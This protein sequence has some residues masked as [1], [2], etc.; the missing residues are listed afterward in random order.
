MVVVQWLTG[1]RPSEVFS[2]RVGDIDRS[3]DNGLWYYS[4][5]H[6]TEEH[7]GEKPIPLGRPE[8]ELITPYLVGKKPEAA[9]FSPRA[10]VRERAEEARAR[11]K[12]KIPPSQQERSKRV[13]DL[14]S[15]EYLEECANIP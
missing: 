3:R 6:K 1:M 11:R 12:S 14:I 2:M 9:V 4:P 8:Q 7:I 15:V 10:A 13:N 5:K